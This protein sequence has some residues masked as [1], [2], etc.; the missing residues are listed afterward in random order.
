MALEL[1]DCS[2]HGPA[3][4][5]P[6]VKF[7]LEEKLKKLNLLAKTTGAEGRALEERWD[8][9]RRKLRQLG[10]QGG[11]RRV[12]NH[13]LEPLVERLVDYAHEPLLWDESFREQVGRCLWWA[14][15]WPGFIVVR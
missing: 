8:V 15:G 5:E 11:D 3:L 9:L 13:V 10:E 4:P 7:Q 14:L 6:F 12:A 2:F 1:R